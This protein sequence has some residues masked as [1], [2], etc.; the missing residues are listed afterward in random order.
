M[1]WEIKDEISDGKRGC[2]PERFDFIQ[3]VRDASNLWA[4]NVDVRQPHQ[5]TSLEHATT[6]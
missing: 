1:Q 4:I 2:D 5:N 6:Q 3:H